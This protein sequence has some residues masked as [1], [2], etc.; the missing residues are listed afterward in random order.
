MGI[1]SEVIRGHDILAVERFWDDTRHMII[2]DILSNRSGLG[3]PWQRLRMF[4]SDDGYAQALASEKR[5]DIKILKHASVV[6]GHLIP[7]KKSKKRRRK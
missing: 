6:E 7:D 4:L 3:K 5:G 2:F 1:H